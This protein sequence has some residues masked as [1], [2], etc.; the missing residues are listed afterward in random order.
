MK[1]K[2]DATGTRVMIFVD[3]FIPGYKAGGQIQSCANLSLALS[4]DLDIYV[5]TTDRDYGEQTAYEGIKTDQWVRN[6]DGMNIYYISPAALSYKTITT[7]LQ[8]VQPHTVYLNSMFSFKFTILP[9]RALMFRK[10]NAA[11]ILAPRGMLQRGALQFKSSK[12]KLFLNLFKWLGVSRKITFHATDETEL[13][14]IQNAFGKEVKVKLVGDYHAAK[15]AAFH[16]LNKS[17]GVLQCLFVSRIVEKKNLLYAIE[18][19]ASVKAQVYFTIIGPVESGAYW[20]QCNKA[21]ARL[22]ENIKVEYKG[23]IPNHDLGSYYSNHHLFVLPTYGENFGHVIFDAFVNGRPVLISDQTPWRNLQA[24]RMG[25]DLPLT[26][27]DSFSKAIETA[28]QWD[29]ADFD[30]Y[31]KNA[32]SFAD[33]FI[34]TSAL[35]Q[36]YIS[37]FTAN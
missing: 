37:L 23:A 17:K 28:A 16:P 14:D 12:K 31:A 4:K 30:E 29:Q 20:E 33:N 10:T 27:P 13:A 15:V 26:E 6:K 18:Q 11:F 21:I 36:K 1:H 2:V 7:L 35:Q 8:E 22:P 9:L 19:L 3:W 32:Y 5:V 24:K 34:A 25:W